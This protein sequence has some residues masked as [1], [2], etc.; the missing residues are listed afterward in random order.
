MNICK[1]ADGVFIYES[2][3]EVTSRMKDAFDLCEALTKAIFDKEQFYRA[4]LDFVSG[5][6]ETRSDT[7]PLATPTHDH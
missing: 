5:A 3:V 6:M 2:L 4:A 7:H 1:R